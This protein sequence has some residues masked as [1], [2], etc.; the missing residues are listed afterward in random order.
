MKV[1]L[2]GG[3]T[4][5]EVDQVMVVQ[6]IDDP[7]DN[8]EPAKIELHINLFKDKMASHV[9]IDDACDGSDVVTYLELGDRLVNGD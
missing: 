2:D 9:F 6:D 5:S 7:T 1:S 3:L 8:E 4:F